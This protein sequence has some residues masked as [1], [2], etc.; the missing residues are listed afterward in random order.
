MNW[1]K[2]IFDALAMTAYFNLLRRAVLKK[3]ASGFT[4]EEKAAMN[5]LCAAMTDK[6]SYKVRRASHDRL[7]MRH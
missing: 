5:E 2:L 1:T 4:K 6:A 3:M 7:A